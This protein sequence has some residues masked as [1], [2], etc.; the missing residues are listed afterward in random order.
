LHA[1]V[2]IEAGKTSQ[3]EYLCQHVAR[4]PISTKRLSLTKNGKVPNPLR[5]PFRDG[6]S[7]FAFEPLV[8]IE[9]SAALVPPTRMHQFTYHGVLARGAPRNLAVGIRGRS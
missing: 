1:E 4:P 3:L 8:F 2:W 9:R 7:H 6:T 5:V